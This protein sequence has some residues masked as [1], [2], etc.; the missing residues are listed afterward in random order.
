VNRLIAQ[1]HALADRVRKLE[2]AYSIVQ[3]L[4]QTGA[5]NR[6][7]ADRA[8]HTETTLEP[9]EVQRRQMHRDLTNVKWLADAADALTRILA[10]ARVSIRTG[11]KITRDVGAG[12]AMDRGAPNAVPAAAVDVVV[13]F[14]ESHSATGQA[15][16][17]LAEIT[18]GHT[19]LSLTLTRLLRVRRAR[20]ICVVSASPDLARAA[21]GALVHNSRITFIAAGTD[22]RRYDP[23]VVRAFRS[24]AAHSWRGGPLSV[25]D[26][27]IEPGQLSDILRS[28]GAAAG[29]LV[30]SDWCLVDP[31]ACDQLIER[32]HE[33]PRGHRLTFSQAAPGLAGCVLDVEVSAQLRRNSQTAGIHAS[34]GGML[35]YVPIVPLADM[36]AKSVC[37]QISPALRDLPLRCIADTPEQGRRLCAALVA[38][39]LDPTVA[40]GPELARVLSR[41]AAAH[42]PQS[43][44]HLTL[45]ISTPARDADRVDADTATR[46]IREFGS[47]TARDRARAPATLTIIDPLGDHP[48]LLD[49]LR[50]AREFSHLC[51]HLRSTFARGT[52]DVASLAPKGNEPLADVISIDLVA[53][54]PE[55]HA[56]LLPE[57]GPAGMATSRTAMNALLAL[58]AD[59]DGAPRGVQLPFVLPRLTRRDEVYSQVEAVVDSSIMLAGWCVLDPMPNPP[60]GA[61]IQ[62]LPLPRLALQREAITTLRIDP[63]AASEIATS[64]ILT[65]W[66]AQLDDARSRG[67]LPAPEAAL[68]RV[69]IA[70]SEAS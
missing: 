32:Y 63:S 58:R 29:L 53:D 13:L 47:L 30:A 31:V 38:A 16:D 26:E 61:R 8:I 46:L 45:T 67:I 9:L 55:L 11:Q 21:A 14:R 25:F 50:T 59:P 56:R 65:A 18:P 40:E 37:V 19:A 4:N 48:A 64:G 33:D 44:A 5:F 6:A 20:G 42:P 62:P 69:P 12:E 22:A 1:A 28:T 7:R 51:V 54:S 35:A 49:L 2:P 70:A 15:A 52:L 17:P 10:D 60:A 24:L 41:D 43:P 66:S 34:I 23:R 39:G 68:E 3:R 57:A 36:I 27:L